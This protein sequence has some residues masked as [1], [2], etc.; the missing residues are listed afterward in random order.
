[1]ARVSRRSM[2]SAAGT[3]AATVAAAKAASFGNPDEPPQGA[4]NTKGNPASLT[5]PGPQNPALGAQFPSAQSPPPTDVS[6]MP[7]F[8]ASFNN[9][10]KR[11]QNGG[12]ARQVTQA[13][14]AIAETISGVD[15]KLTAGGIREMH[16]HLAAEWGFVTSGACR[17][18]ILDEMGR[19]QVADV[20]QGDI[21]YFPA[22]LPHSLQG[23]GPDGCEFLL[24][25]DDGKATEYN[26]LLIT[27]W[28][29]HTPPQILAENFG[30]PAETF[31]KIPLHQLYI[32][33]GE[34]PGPL[35]VDQAAVKGKLGFPPN[36]FTFSLGSMPPTRQT[37]GGE[38]RIADSGNF[39][40]SKTIAAAMVTLRPGALREMHWHP[41][42]DEWQYWIKGKGRMTVFDS[43]PR[44]VTMDFNPGDI[45]YVKRS[46][47]HYIQNVGDTDLQFLEV[48]RSPY[49]ADVSL[50][51]WVTHTP[52]ALVAQH[53]NIDPATIAK[54]PNNKPEVMPE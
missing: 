36:S 45:G 50:S 13:D 27:E 6:D 8:W 22:G 42:A 30:V 26:T 18:T 34:L 12:W 46:N 31:A 53:L 15:M 38:V 9:A 4:L 54:F 39:L 44:A 1:M 32:F 19:A 23:L 52:P 17:V 41:N 24:C 7:M 5:D 49:F 25:F 21:W 3:V 20:K 11:I 48:F 16:W 2:L 28:L 10:P 43:G 47:G 37:R 14:F 33:Q 29:A 40:V 51:D 35:A